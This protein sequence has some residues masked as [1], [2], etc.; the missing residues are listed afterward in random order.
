MKYDVFIQNAEIFLGIELSSFKS[1]CV[2]A[3]EK[4]ESNRAYVPDAEIIRSYGAVVFA[5]LYCFLWVVVRV[6][7]C[8]DSL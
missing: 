6:M 4:G 3:S 5:M 7:V 1:S 2:H 8:L